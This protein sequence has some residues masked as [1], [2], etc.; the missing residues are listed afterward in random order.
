MFGIVW[1]N[2]LSKHIKAYC[3][4]VKVY[5]YLKLDTCWDWGTLLPTL[6]Q[7]ATRHA[8]CFALKYVQSLDQ[9]GWIPLVKNFGQKVMIS[10]HTYNSRW[11]TYGSSDSCFLR[12]C[13]A[14]QLLQSTRVWHQNAVGWGSQN[15]ETFLWSITVNKH[16]K[17]AWPLG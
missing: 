16:N 7:P 11:M 14:C 8:V 9:L 3:N 13:L 15:W 2:L 10:R 17:P 5:L 4:L 1:W 12:I 6:I